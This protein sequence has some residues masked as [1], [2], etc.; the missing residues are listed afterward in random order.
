MQAYLYETTTVRPRGH[1]T[2]FGYSP[3][4]DGGDGLD[5]KPTFCRLICLVSF[6][7]TNAILRGRRTGIRLKPSPCV[8]ILLCLYSCRISRPNSGPDSSAELSRFRYADDPSQQGSPPTSRS[9][10]AG[11][12]WDDHPAGGSLEQRADPPWARG[13][14]DARPVGGGSLDQR[15]R[16]PSGSSSG[17]RRTGG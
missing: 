17:V 13:G 14:A 12:C 2:I 1:Q 11:P 3:R 9:Y 7:C 6:L 8:L 4:S 16:P 15:L 5:H 10:P